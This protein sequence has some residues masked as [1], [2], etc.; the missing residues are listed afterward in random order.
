MKLILSTAALV[1]AFA[2]TAFAG[3][4]AYVDDNGCTHFPILNAE[5]VANYWN[6]GL[7][8]GCGRVTK[9][10]GDTVEIARLE[11]DDEEK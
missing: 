10:G 9:G 8:A 7:E 2:T 3:D 1:L 5:G 11:K 4:V 6:L